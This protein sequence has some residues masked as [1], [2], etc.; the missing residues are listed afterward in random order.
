MNFR[1]PIDDR[2]WPAAIP[3]DVL[4]ATPPE[5][6]EESEIPRHG[7]IRKLVWL[8]FWLLLIEGALRKWILP[9]L[10]TPLLV[11]RDPVVILMY[12]VALSEGVFPRNGF[13]IWSVFLAIASAFASLFVGQDNL[14]ITLFGLRTSFL[15][16]PL[17]FLIPKVFNLR[18]VEKMG[19]WL[20][21]TAVPM[22][23]LVLL[24]FRSSPNSWVNYGVGASEGAQLTVGFGKIRPPGTFSFTNGLAAYLSLLVAFVMSWQIK[25]GTINAKV[26]LAAIPAA[27]VMIG[28]S[29]SRGVLTAVTLILAG[30]VY[31]C[32]SRREF[33]GKGL[34]AALLIGLAFFVLHFFTAFRQ[35]MIIHQDRLSTGGGVRDGLVGRVLGGFS[36]P[37]TVIA[38][39]PW[40]GSGIGLGTT[41]AGGLLYGERAFLLAEGEWMRIIR[42][43]GPILGFAYLGLRVAIAVAIG[44]GAFRALDQE[45]PLPLLLFCATCPSVLS[46]QFGVPTILGF[47]TFG[48]GLCLAASNLPRTVKRTEPFRIS[49]DSATNP[50]R[51]V[52]GRSIY[53]E[54][55]HGR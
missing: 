54:K 30:V 20:L 7:A 19:S 24:Q 39:T 28:V 37:F 8:Y 34:R 25:R 10:A 50:N 21:L 3:R 18:D 52:R 2:T 55:L 43:S 11:V 1:P 14:L 29:G 47:A 33:F 12:L 13:I 5:L 31:V 42:E 9:Q 38:E 23:L 46:G 6:D 45:N 53:A 48:A 49:P 32:L 27:G 44:W 17:I 22:A 35:G 36:E 4:T 26:A 41:A 15:H 40:L 16:L 51:T